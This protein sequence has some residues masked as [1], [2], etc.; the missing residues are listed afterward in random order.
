MGGALDAL[1]GAD[2]ARRIIRY[3]NDDMISYSHP[4]GEAV[5][6]LNIPS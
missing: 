3:R 6:S 2:V 5:A 1:D 4:Y